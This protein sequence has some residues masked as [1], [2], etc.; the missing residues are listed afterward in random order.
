MLWR[1]GAGFT[2][3]GFT[4]AA[5]E[6]AA[7]L[8]ET[9]VREEAVVVAVTALLSDP[10]EFWL[11]EVTEVREPLPVDVETVFWRVVWLEVLDVRF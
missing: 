8:S 9:E 1:S 2:S 10:D 3:I 4:G 6:P 5:C 7:G 11:P